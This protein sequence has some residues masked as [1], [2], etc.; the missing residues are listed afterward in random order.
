MGL[1]LVN[2]SVT[3][4]PITAMISSILED[5]HKQTLKTIHLQIQHTLQG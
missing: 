3:D 2:N 5:P 1:L 4:I